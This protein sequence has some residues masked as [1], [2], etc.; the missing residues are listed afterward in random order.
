MKALTNP[1]IIGGLVVAGLVFYAIQEPFHA[2]A[3]AV[4]IGIVVLLW[5]VVGRRRR[6]AEAPK[7][8]KL[9]ETPSLAPDEAPTGAHVVAEPQWSAPNGWTYHESDPHLSNAWRTMG[10]TLTGDD[11]VHNVLVSKAAVLPVVVFQTQTESGW[12]T[13]CLV[14]AGHLHPFTAVRN[15]DETLVLQEGSY[16]PERA[17]SALSLLEGDFAGVEAHSPFLVSRVIR[18]DPHTVSQALECVPDLVDLAQALRYET[19]AEPLGSFDGTP[20]PTQVTEVVAPTSH[21]ATSVDPTPAI[22]PK[23]PSPASAS[24]AEQPNATPAT[25]WRP[26]SWQ[27]PTW[28]PPD[29]ADDSA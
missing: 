3:W 20:A 4:G 26:T 17:L 18:S 1:W 27:P 21:P 7:A 16:A 8:A 19:M 29:Y 2:L 6:T 15:E 14:W 10:L 13:W 28:Q 23:Q 9:A 25:D 24:S 22:V 11:T 12:R 5:F